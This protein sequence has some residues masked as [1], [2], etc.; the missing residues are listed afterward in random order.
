MRLAPAIAALIAMASGWQYH[1]KSSLSKRHEAKS[2][3]AISST[4]KE[5]PNTLVTSDK[6]K[7]SPPRSVTSDQFDP[8][9]ANAQALI[10]RGLVDAGAQMLEKL[11]EQ[12]PTDTQA[13]MEMAMIYTMDLK[14]PQRARLILERVL[15]VNPHHRAALNELELLYKELDAVDDGLSLLELKAQQHPDSLEIQYTYGRLLASSNPS[16]AIPWLQRATFIAD[17]KEQALDQLAATAL[18]AGNVALAVKSW[19]KR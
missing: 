10:D 8:S 5:T 4:K 2:E 15:D 13:L 19:S 18:R 9:I 7:S 11:I 3:D 12:D 17:Q 6:A 1:L 16:A 14:E